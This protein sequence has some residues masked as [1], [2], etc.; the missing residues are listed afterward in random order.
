M[1][2]YRDW[3]KTNFTLAYAQWIHGVNRGV[4]LPPG[5]D[6]QWLISVMYVDVC[7]LAALT[8]IITGTTK[9][10]RC[11]TLTFSQTLPRS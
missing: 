4:L 8:T 1:R 9:R 7:S 2:N 10:M 3:K 5:L 6:E 11:A